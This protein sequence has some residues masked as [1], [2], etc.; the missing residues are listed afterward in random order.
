MNQMTL[1]STIA[2]YRKGA[3]ITQEA[4]AQ[5]LNVT[6][7]AVSKWELDICCADVQLLPQLADIFQISLDQLFGRD[8]G[9]EP[10]PAAAPSA[11]PWEDDRTL[12]AVLFIGHK[13][14]DVKERDSYADITQFS[15]SYDGPAMN[16]ASSFS[17]YC[18][19]DVRGNVSADGNVECQAVSGYAS[20][21]GSI[22]CCDIG[23]NAD[24]GGD[25]TC[26][27]IDGDADAGGSIFCRSF[28]K[29]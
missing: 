20:A 23:G 24:A 10:A 4:L 19:G 22:E 5:K 9:P 26:S 14:V 8:F 17:V 13:L 28:K 27:D 21:G 12:R 16:I 3:G 7:Q 2:A 1:G 15:F 11:L 18:T 29:E 6:N 25:I